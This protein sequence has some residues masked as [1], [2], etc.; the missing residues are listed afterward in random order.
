MNAEIKNKISE[1]GLP[2]VIYGASTV[3]EVL[4][5]E[6][7]RN[8]IQVSVFCDY[9]INK[10]GKYFC[11][12]RSDPYIAI[13]GTV[14]KGIFYHFGGRDHRSTEEIRRIRIF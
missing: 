13:K 4:A 14:S 6:L 7:A 5:D 9:N 3:G 10:A 2:I 8:N 11:G 1:C 12:K